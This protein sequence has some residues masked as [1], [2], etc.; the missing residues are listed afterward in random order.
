[1]I[2]SNFWI[3]GFVPNSKWYSVHSNVT[4]MYNRLIYLNK[5]HWS[6]DLL[7]FQYKRYHAHCYQVT[8]FLILVCPRQFEGIHIPLVV[9]AL[10]VV[11]TTHFGKLGQKL[12]SLNGTPP[13]ILRIHHFLLQSL[14]TTFNIPLLHPESTVRV[15]SEG[16]HKGGL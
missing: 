5:I 13:F 3:F 9:P 15:K 8:V 10:F 11:T 7:F 12:P 6:Y 4:K 2:M 14:R 16:K 1:M